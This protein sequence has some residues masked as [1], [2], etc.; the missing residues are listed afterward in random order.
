[1]AFREE[2]IVHYLLDCGSLL[3][4]RVEDPSDETLG[5][6]RNLNILGENVVILFDSL[7]GGLDVV[8]LERRLA[9]EQSVPDIIVR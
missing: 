2:G 7:I 1:M 5:C 9:D 6:D 8:R 4:V 3:R